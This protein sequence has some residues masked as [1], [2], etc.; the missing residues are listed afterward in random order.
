MHGA[1]LLNLLILEIS[2]FKT[3]NFVNILC[4][5]SHHGMQCSN[6][7]LVIDMYSNEILCF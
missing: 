4:L 7:H 1:S 3:V 6:C 2:L 5:N